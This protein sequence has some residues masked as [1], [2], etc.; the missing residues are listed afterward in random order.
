MGLYAAGI[1]YLSSRHFIK[2]P[3]PFPYFDKLVHFVM[4]A[5]FAFLVARAVAVCLAH[6][7]RF[8]L[9]MAIV[10]SAM[11]GVSDEVHQYFVPMR[12]CD[13][14]DWVADLLGSVAGVFVYA[15]FN[16]WMLKKYWRLC[17]SEPQA[18]NLG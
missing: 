14:W 10:I 1:F 4:Y 13:L 5:G 7:D 3:P 9:W 2:V 11:Y 18:K 6:V 15:T 16:Y 17:H 12:S 8:T